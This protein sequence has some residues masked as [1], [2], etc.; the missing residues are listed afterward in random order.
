MLHG[1]GQV[2]PHGT[3]RDLHPI[4]DLGMA[5]PFQLG[6]QERLAHLAGQSVE[7]AIDFDQASSARARRSGDG[8]C[9]ASQA[10]S[11]SR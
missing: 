6:Q 10:C 9:P 4:G 7:Q 8:A 11:A 5:Q 1:A 3:H 2:L